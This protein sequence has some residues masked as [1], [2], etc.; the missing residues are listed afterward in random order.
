MIVYL[1][2]MLSRV[3]FPLLLEGDLKNEIPA[4]FQNA[5]FFSSLFYE[6]DPHFKSLQVLE[7]YVRHKNIIHLV[8][9]YDVKEVI[10]FL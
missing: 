5:S 10:C 7:N 3:I 8:I 9:E 6:L 1:E 2:G 4:P